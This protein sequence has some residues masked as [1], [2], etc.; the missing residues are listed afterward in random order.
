MFRRLDAWFNALTGFGTWRDPTTHTRFQADEP[1]LPNELTDFYNYDD[2]VRII[3]SCFAEEMLREG[4]TVKCSD[5]EWSARIQ[6]RAEELEICERFFD[7]IVWGR[8]YGGAIMWPGANDGRD[9]REPLGQI[10][11]LDFIDVYDRR[12]VFPW[13]YFGTA[14]YPDITHPETWV[15]YPLQG[16]M[17]AWEPNT[18]QGQTYIH[19]S[20]VIRFGGAHTDEYSKRLLAGWDFS[21]LQNI[22]EPIKI[23]HETFQG[24]RLML[25][26]ASQAVLKLKGL[27]AAL[28]GGKRDDLQARAQLLDMSRSVARMVMLD[29]DENESFEK[30]ATQFAGLA[31]VMAMNCKRLSAATRIPVAVLMGESP[32]GLQATGASDIRLFYDHVNSGRKKLSGAF[33]KVLRMIAK[34]EGYEGTVSVEWPSLWQNS[35][36]EEADV[37]LKTAQGDEIYLTNEVLTP[38]EVAKSRFRKDGWS[39]ETDVDLEHRAQLYKAPTPALPAK[40]DQPDQPVAKP[41][42]S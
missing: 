6:A 26:D 28:S 38:E 11:S 33:T 21:V 4:F 25:R 34:S 16:T 5:P 17:T 3:V 29:S 39:A 32:A 22:Q 12:Y 23:F 24:T 18:R 37:R 2:I 7:A 27:V 9:P 8:L 42:D 41:E 30:V 15:V 36:T 31:D 10:K 20:R 35:P 13:T 19:E 14:G 40:P 1:L